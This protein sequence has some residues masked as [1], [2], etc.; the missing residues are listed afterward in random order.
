[1]ARSGSVANVDLAVQFPVFRKPSRALPPPVGVGEE[2]IGLRRAV[3]GVS[4]AWCFVF[5]RLPGPV[6]ARPRL[7][8]VVEAVVVVAV[9]IGDVDQAVAV[10]VGAGI[11]LTSPSGTPSSS[12]SKMS[13]GIGPHRGLDR[14]EDPSP[15]AS[16]PAVNRACVTR[17]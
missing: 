16:V 10:G 9:G 11:D 7:R 13:V 3:V 4:A 14:V 15:S 2:R 1:L 17:F 6:A 8:Y 12:L 5:V